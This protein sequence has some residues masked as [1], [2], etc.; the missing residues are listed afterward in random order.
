MIL[1]FNQSQVR[2]G[3]RPESFNPPLTLLLS[4]T[5]S[6]PLYSPLANIVARGGQLAAHENE[7]SGYSREERVPQVAN[8]KPAHDQVAETLECR[9]LPC[10]PTPKTAP[11]CSLHRALKCARLC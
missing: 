5:R 3:S 7:S 9:V 8:R 6:E 10:P 11:A 1:C 4:T 2:V